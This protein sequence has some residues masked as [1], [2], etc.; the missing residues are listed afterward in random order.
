MFR[1][2]GKQYEFLLL[3]RIPE[4]GG[5]WQPPCGGMEESDKSLLDAAFRE[6][7]EEVNI[8]KKDVIKVIENVHYFEFNN[9]YI[10]GE[11]IPVR[12]EYVFGFEAKSGFKP[13]I[14]KNIYVEHNEIRW[15]GFEDAIR[16]LKWDNNKEAFQKLNDMLAKKQKE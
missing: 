6:L 7:K 8:S 4:K 9:H 13:D 15:V 12:K 11:P 3:K 1:K 5:F 2:K 16:L 10:T 14:G